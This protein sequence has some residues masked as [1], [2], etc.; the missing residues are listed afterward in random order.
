[1]SSPSQQKERRER[2]QD[3]KAHMQNENIIL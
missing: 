1:M 2:G 3:G